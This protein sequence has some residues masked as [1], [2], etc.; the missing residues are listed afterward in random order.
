MD[1][2]AGGLPAP[3]GSRPGLNDLDILF[4]TDPLV[5]VK[6]IE[7]QPEGKRRAE[8]R[9]LRRIRKDFK[10]R[11]TAAGSFSIKGQASS[12]WHGSFTDNNTW[13]NYSL[14][15]LQAERTE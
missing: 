2:Q 7:M 1:R 13:G 8:F 3:R 5:L 6:H 14:E 12:A 4:E 10:F 11:I 9:R 15:Q